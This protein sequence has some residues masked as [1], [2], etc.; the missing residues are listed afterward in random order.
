EG[1]ICDTAGGVSCSH[2]TQ[3]CVPLGATGQACSTTTD[4][5]AADYC[6]FSGSTSM[7]A[8][9][10]PDGASCASSFDACQKTSYCD[11]SQKC[12]PASPDGAAC[13][14]GITTP[15]QS[16]ACI[17]GKCG[18]SGSNLGLALICG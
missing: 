14:S 4:C 13:G 18:S 9:R 6:V 11:S 17:N 1:F 16:N 12:A 8:A 2:A 5:V 10:L 15:C 3:K 7:C